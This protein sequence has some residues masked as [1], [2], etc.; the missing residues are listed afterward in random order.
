MASCCEHGRCRDKWQAVVSMVGVGTSG[1][2][3]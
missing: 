2:L 1:K 3:L